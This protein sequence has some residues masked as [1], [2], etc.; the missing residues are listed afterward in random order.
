MKVCREHNAPHSVWRIVV[1]RESPGRFL[2]SVVP[3]P[4]IISIKATVFLH[5][6]V[7]LALHPFVPAKKLTQQLEQGTTPPT[8]NPPIRPPVDMLAITNN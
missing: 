7:F 8:N 4:Y 5:P 3:R 6:H 2:F 1:S